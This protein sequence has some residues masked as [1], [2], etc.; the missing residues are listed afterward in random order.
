MS[1]KNTKVL[2]LNAGYGQPPQSKG[3]LNHSLSIEI[4]KYL[5]QKGHETKITHM[6]QGYD[7][8]DEVSKL[9]WADVIIL[10]TPTWWLGLPGQ[11]KTYIDLVL[12]EYFRIPNKKE[13]KKFMVSCT[14]ACNEEALYDPN[15]A[16]QG[17]GPD[18]VYWT[19]YQSFF[20]SG[21]GK[22][23]IVA[24]NDA[25]NPNFNFDEAVS[26]LHSHLDKVFQ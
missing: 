8:K 4:E 11:A 23:P 21:I 1:L 24:F 2:I 26:K 3:S 6:D 13:G 9:D 19:V 14:F 5:K 22:L 7:V 17:L 20:Y 16:Y 10:Q 18:Q 15:S 12:S 25:S